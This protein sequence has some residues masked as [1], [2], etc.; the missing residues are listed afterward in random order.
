QNLPFSILSADGCD[1]DGDG[2]PNHLDADS[3]GDGCS[4]AREAGY[5]DPDNDGFLG[6]S[7]VSVD[8]G[9][10]VTGQGGYTTPTDADGNGIYDFLEA[11]SV[12]SISIQPI[13]RLGFDGGSIDFSVT[14][15]ADTY[16]WQVSTNGGSTFSDI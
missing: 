11:G 5:T 6:T 14:A 8:A 1:E 3:D 2:I 12:P 4:D 16:Q 7:P 9:G 10:L 13:N 15:A